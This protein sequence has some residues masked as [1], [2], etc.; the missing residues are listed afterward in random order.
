M[1]TELLVAGLWAVVGL[2]WLW[3]RRPATADKVGLFHRELAVLGGTTPS[4]VPPANRLAP[5]PPP[6][7]AAPAA[8]SPLR[9]VGHRRALDARR[10][11]RDVVFS[12]AFFVL[13]SLLVVALTRSVAAVAV[14][15]IFD[16]ALVAYLGLLASIT[17]ARPLPREGRAA[18]APRPAPPVHARRAGP[19]PSR[20]EPYGDFESYES[21]ALA[22]AN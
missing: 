18:P 13:L 20:V 5:A 21:L 11:R 9:P 16:L 22:R 6:V 10:R 12:L 15:A 2:Y 3:S 17:R 14:Q 4:R 7:A 8:L 19:S 1:G